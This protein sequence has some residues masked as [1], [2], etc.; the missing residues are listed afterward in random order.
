MLVQRRAAMAGAGLGLDAAGCRPALDPADH[1]RGTDVEQTR[2]LPRAVTFLDNRDD[3]LPKVFRVSLRHLALPP[4]SSEEPN[5]I[6]SLEGTPII[7]PIQIR[8]KALYLRPIE[9]VDRSRRNSGERPRLQANCG[10]HGRRPSL[11]Q[12]WLQLASRSRL[13]CHHGEDAKNARHERGDGQLAVMNIFGSDE[14]ARGFWLVEALRLEISTT[15][16]A[17]AG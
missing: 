10:L 14:S 9:L 12:H 4:L 2:R 17:G 1:R 16:L 15:T 13:L 8:R 3:P 6:C 11:H 7:L 5:L